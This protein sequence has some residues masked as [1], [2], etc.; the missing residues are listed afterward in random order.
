MR[1]TVP[2]EELATNP[3]T[4]DQ[5]IQIEKMLRAIQKKIKVYM[6]FSWI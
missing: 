1:F 2:F 3:I 4:F 6:H 5:A